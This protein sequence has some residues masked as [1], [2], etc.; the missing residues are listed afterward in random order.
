MVF[1]A[2]S[3]LPASAMVALAQGHSPSTQGARAANGPAPVV[4]RFNEALVSSMKSGAELGYKARYGRLETVIDATYDFRSIARLSVGDYWNALSSQ[5]Q[6]TLIKTLRRYTIANYASEFDSYDGER[7]TVES[8]Q[9]LRPGTEV[10]KSTFM[11]KSGQPEHRFEYVLH[12]VDD[13][14]KVINVV[15][16]GVSDLSMKRSQYRA[17]IRSQGFDTLIEKL[18]KR[19]DKLSGNS[20]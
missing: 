13:V 10:V 6:Q 3:L 15:V 20:G 1:F 18:D 9:Q 7:F 19:I 17:I 16:D 4:Q 11:G 8:Q 12:E 2:L 5:Q 14:W